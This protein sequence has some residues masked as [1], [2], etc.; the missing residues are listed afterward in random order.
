MRNNEEEGLGRRSRSLQTLMTLEV[1]VCSRAEG[2]SEAR[3]GVTIQVQKHHRS[4]A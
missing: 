3:E 4:Q 2:K 1:H